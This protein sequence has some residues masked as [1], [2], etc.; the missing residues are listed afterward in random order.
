MIVLF[1]TKTTFQPILLRLRDKARDN[2]E[3]A[4][5]LLAVVTGPERSPLS[6]SLVTIE[7]IEEALS[8]LGGETKYV[9]R[10]RKSL[11][12]PNVVDTSMSPSATDTTSSCPPDTTNQAIKNTADDVQELPPGAGI[13]LDSIATLGLD[14]GDVYT[15]LYGQ[16]YDRTTVGESYDH[17]QIAFANV[18]SGESSAAGLGGV[19]IIRSSA[20]QQGG[21]LDADGLAFWGL[22][23]EFNS[24]IAPTAAPGSYAPQFL[25]RGPEVSSVISNPSAGVLYTNDPSTTSGASSAEADLLS[26]AVDNPLSYDFELG[27]GMAVY[28]EPGAYSQL[29]SEDDLVENAWRSIMEDPQFA[30]IEPNSLLPFSSW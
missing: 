22:Q 10:M 7:P 20:Q 16:L 24:Q 15:W 30:S 29:G 2:F 26:M 28:G 3:R 19:P 1:G 8:L 5:S 11:G 18:L 25:Q 4:D 27:E 23:N 12:C 17:N 21:G 9:K 13:Q 6:R 14:L